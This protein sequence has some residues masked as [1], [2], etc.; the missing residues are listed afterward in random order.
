VIVQFVD[1][2][3][4]RVGPERG[5]RKQVLLP[6]RRR[7]PD[8][9]RGGLVEVLALHFIDRMGKP[10]VGSKHPHHFPSVI[11]IFAKLCYTK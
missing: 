10:D 4:E 9:P 7:L 3:F 8:D 11:S 6:I 2:V 5:K 1:W